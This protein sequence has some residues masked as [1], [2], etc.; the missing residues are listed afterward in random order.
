MHI[1]KKNESDKQSLL[2][3]SLLGIFLLLGAFINEPERDGDAH[4]YVLM[5]ESLLQH[6]S[7]D[8]RLSDLKGLEHIA[9][10]NSSF[11]LDGI[12]SLIK[13]DIKYGEDL[14]LGYIKSYT[15]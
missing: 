5:Q 13:N 10:I 8:L 12:A 4:E 2:I 15:G 11:S 9:E 1:I 14:S 6:G 3:V 7:V